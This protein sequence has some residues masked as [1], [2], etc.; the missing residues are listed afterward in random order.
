M[1]MLSVVRAADSRRRCIHAA[2]VDPRE[3]SM[4]IADAAIVCPVS[5]GVSSFLQSSINTEYIVTLEN[6]HKRK[7]SG[8]D[9]METITSRVKREAMNANRAR[10]M[11]APR[12]ACQHDTAQSR[13]NIHA[14]TALGLLLSP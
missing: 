13:K 4:S 10:T 14:A 7:V 5:D 11:I 8:K 3:T 2:S 9:A 1:I 6:A 12:S